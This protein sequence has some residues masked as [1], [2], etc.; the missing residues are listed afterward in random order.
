MSL[1]HDLK[2]YDLYGWDNELFN[3]LRQKEI[4]WHLRF[5]RLTRGPMLELGG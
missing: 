1:E 5:A 4:A 2:R 3:P